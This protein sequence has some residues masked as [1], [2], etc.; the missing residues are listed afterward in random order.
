M[1]TRTTT[2]LSTAC[3]LAA[4]IEHYLYLDGEWYCEADISIVGPTQYFRHPSIEPLWIAY[5]ADDDPIKLWRRGEPVPEAIL[6]AAPRSEWAFVAH[7]ASFDRLGCENVLT[8]QDDWPSIPVE[9]W[10]CTMAQAASFALPHGLGDLCVAL[11]V[12]HQKDAEGAKLMREMTQPSKRTKSKGKKGKNKDEPQSDVPPH[13]DPVR[14]QRL[15]LYVINDAEALRA[16]HLAMPA[17]PVGE[18]ERW[19]HN[20]RVNAR[21]VP[22]DRALA[23]AGREVAILTKPLLD[24]EMANVTSGKVPA[25]TQVPKLKAW[26]AAAGYPFKSLGKK[27]VAK[28]LLGPLDADVRS[29]LEIRSEGGKNTPAKFAKMLVNLGDD[30]RARDLLVYHQASTGRYSSHRINIHNLARTPL[31]APEAAIAA[32]ISRDLD[33]IRV[34]GPPLEVLANVIRATICALA[35]HVFGGGD[36]S[37]IEARVLAWLVNERRKLKAFIEYDQTSNP[38]LDPYLVTACLIFSVAPG[39]FNADAP[40]R[41]I[42]KTGDLA[43]GY[44]GG[45]PAWR[46]FEDP[47]HPRPDAEVEKFKELWRKAHPNVVRFW[48]AIKDAA[49]DAVHRPGRRVHCGRVVLKKVDEHLYIKLPSGRLLCYPFAHIEFDSK[50][51]KQ[52]VFKDNAKGGWC[53]QRLWHGTLTENIVSGIARDLLCAALERVEAAGFNTIFHVHDEIVVE[54]D[55]ATVTPALLERFKSLMIEKPAWADGLP[56]AAKIWSGR[57]YVK[58]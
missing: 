23:A 51:R 39:T 33:C 1:L 40:E 53:D 16:V 11:N 45:I 54:M 10:R 7:N 49:I 37:G 26:L 43:F 50:R 34:L 35:G 31:K 25:V 42:G 9:Q 6:Y 38:K 52:V 18:V 56:M 4:A 36:F 32:V 58:S 55:E 3:P 41:Q 17:M 47:R 15:G 22:I 57:R 8:P 20:E 24:K 48:Y 19:I 44:A 30:D 28:A 29:V 21:G 13:K 27:Q 5:A 2:L 12:K 46:N 14:L